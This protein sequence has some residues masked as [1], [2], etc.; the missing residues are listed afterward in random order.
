MD[1]SPIKTA[2]VRCR[3]FNFISSLIVVLSSVLLPHGTQA[4]PSPEP[5][6]KS[7]SPHKESRRITKDTVADSPPHRS[8]IVSEHETGSSPG[9]E[10]SRGCVFPSL[11][12]DRTHV[13]AALLFLTVAGPLRHRPDSLL[14][15][16]GGTCFLCSSHLYSHHLNLSSLVCQLKITE[17]N[18][19]I[20]IS[21]DN[22]P[23]LDEADGI[24]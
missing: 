21:C 8:W 10:S 18:S 22:P 23:M 12:S 19:Q 13:H 5:H 16:I 9:L 20:S 17:N 15:P 4:A 11:L 2:R 24:L 1:K 7:G 6:R 3:F 14:S